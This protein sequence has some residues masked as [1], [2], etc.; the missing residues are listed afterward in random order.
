L[1]QDG[2]YRFTRNP[3]YLSFAV[4]YLGLAFI[5]NSVYLLFVLGIVLI[6]LDRTQIPNEERYLREKFGEEYDRYKDKVR[7]WI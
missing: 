5:F 6:L 7:R 2:P 1:V 4:I 3:I